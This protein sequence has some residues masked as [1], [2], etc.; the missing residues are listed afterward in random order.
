MP[1]EV[2][3]KQCG[4]CI[5]RKD[6]SLDLAKLEAEVADERM[7]GFFSGFRICHSHSSAC[8]RGF[9]NQHKDEFQLGQLAQRLGQVR[10][11]SAEKSHDQ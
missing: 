2:M 9:W 7:P 3:S 11:V 4:T 10:F 5:Y 1:F 6:S 8:Y